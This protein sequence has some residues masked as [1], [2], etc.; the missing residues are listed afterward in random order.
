MSG[1][2]RSG[3]AL[4][5]AVR[6]TR[7]VSGF[8]AASTRT[9]AAATSRT[10]AM[11]PSALSIELSRVCLDWKTASSLDA[12]G[13]SLDHDL[14]AAVDH[15]LGVEGHRLGVH[16]LRQALILHDLGVDAIAVLARLV[17]DP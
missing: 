15:A 7:N 11:T 4:M 10:A 14:E 5:L 3:G 2:I 1:K 16:R 9:A 13:S 17:D 12:P 8:I 6:W